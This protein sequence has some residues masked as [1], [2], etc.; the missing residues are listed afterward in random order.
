VEALQNERHQLLDQCRPCAGSSRAAP[1][2]RCRRDAN[3]WPC[4]RPSTA[5]DKDLL[6]LRDALDAKDRQ[7]LDQK[8]RYRELGAGPP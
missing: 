2:R 7:I 3:T 4:A 1:P 6:D 8:D 5:R